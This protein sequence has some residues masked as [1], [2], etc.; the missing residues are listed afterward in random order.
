MRAAHLGAAAAIITLALVSLL[1]LGRSPVY[2]HGPVRAWSG[3]V[4][5]DQNSQQLT[6][7]YTF[8][9]VTHGIGLYAMVRLLAPRSRMPGRMLA[10]LALECAWEV[11]ENTDVVIERYRTAT[12]AQGYYG[13][14]VLNSFGDI[15][16]TIAGFAFAA[17]LPTPVTVVLTILLEVGLGLWIRDGL[18]LNILMLV[19]P[20][21]A[22]RDWQQH[23][24]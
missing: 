6:D 9:H 22:I 17:L 11:I 7:P 2:R 3:D 16:A 15:L 10:A 18:L 5:S 20:V 23:G 14:S 1:A 24:T 21:E 13:D 4:G 19:W 12:M 8:T